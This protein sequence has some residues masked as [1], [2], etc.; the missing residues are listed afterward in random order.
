[1]ENVTRRDFIGIAGA[2]AASAALAAPALADQISYDAEDMG[3]AEVVL[4]ETTDGK[5]GMSFE[6]GVEDFDAASFRAQLLEDH[7]CEYVCSDGTVIPAVYNQLRALLN[8]LGLGNG[9]ELTDASFGEAMYLFSEDEAAAYITMPVGE[10]FTATEWA[11]RTG[12][13]EAEC[14]E[15]CET[16]ATRGLLYRERRAG[17]P[18]FHMLAEAHGIW[19][20]NLI[21]VSAE[22]TGNLADFSAGEETEKYSV[23]HQ[24][25]W[26]SDIITHLYN[27][28]TP[29]YYAVP[30]NQD[31]V[32]DTQILPYDD[33]EAVIDRN[34]VF[35]VSPCQCRLR[36]NAM[37]D[38]TNT[39]VEGQCDHPIETCLS[40]GL[41]AEYYIENGIARQIDQ[42]E[43]REILRRSVDEG[44]VI[45][46]CY[47][48]DS[49]IF[50]SCHGDCC[51]ILA[52]YVACG[53][54]YMGM[55]NSTPQ[56]SHYRL[57][58]DHDLCIK[59]GACA[60]RCPLFAITMD[61]EEGPVVDNKCVRCGQCAL[62]CPVEARKL[63]QKDESEIL[64]L[65]QNMLEDYI[66]KGN[67]R[68]S[69]GYVY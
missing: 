6:A 33:Y 3:T 40:T 34:T 38:Y 20:Y 31:V 35:G 37:G 13:D 5:P 62:V 51:D 11:Y 17:V 22:E 50:C 67:Y 47:T 46:S 27:S 28:E 60:E 61:E 24:N 41:M 15:L 2:A 1:M 32:A 18:Y 10:F 4:A 57:E 9:S 48:K 58:V 45:Q 8:T 30:V 54:D 44:M 21:R 42:D 49:E 7:N 39:V 59:C 19:E 68:M 16:L 64:E 26:G 56:L 63:V 66:L 29:F 36:R 23:L 14:L 12:R 65:P 43:A 25:H 69:H 55:L 52:S 53:S